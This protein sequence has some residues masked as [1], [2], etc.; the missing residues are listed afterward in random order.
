MGK[1][2]SL[3]GRSFFG[4]SC[5]AN[6]PAELVFY[7]AKSAHLVSWQWHPGAYIAGIAAVVHGQR[8]TAASSWKSSAVRNYAVVAIFPLP[9]KL[10][11]EMSTCC[12]S[13]GKVTYLVGLHCVI[14]NEWRSL[15]ETISCTSMCL[16]PQVLGFGFFFST[17]HG[18]SEILRFFQSLINVLLSQ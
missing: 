17:S 2:K 12:S 15:I 3:P 18:S 14:A 16:E 10:S 5:C 4:T 7:A 11:R 13:P 1:V 9:Y 6:Y 8:N